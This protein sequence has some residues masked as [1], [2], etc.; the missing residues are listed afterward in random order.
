MLYPLLCSRQPY[1]PIY[2]R[3]QIQTM[4]WKSLRAHLGLPQLKS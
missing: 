3:I 1:R 2:T 4:G